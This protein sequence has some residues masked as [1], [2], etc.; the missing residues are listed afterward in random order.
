MI[1]YELQYEHIRATPELVPAD[2][3]PPHE[4]VSCCVQSYQRQPV[5]LVPNI[6][7]FAIR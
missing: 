2:S 6:P 4:S 1:I 3:Y 7:M 5:I